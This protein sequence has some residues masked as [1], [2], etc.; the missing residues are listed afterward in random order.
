MVFAMIFTVNA[1]AIGS[2]SLVIRSRNNC[3][4]NM[5]SA[6]KHESVERANALTMSVFNPGIDE[7]TYAPRP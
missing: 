7:L 4:A 2:N 5:L 6:T 3:Q 1:N